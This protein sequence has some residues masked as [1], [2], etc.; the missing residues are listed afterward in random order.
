MWGQSWWR[1]NVWK[2]HWLNCWCLCQCVCLCS[3]YR[4]D[5]CLL[6]PPHLSCIKYSEERYGL[7]LSGQSIITDTD[8]YSPHFTLCLESD[9]ISYTLISDIWAECNKGFVFLIRGWPVLL[10]ALPVTMQ[11]FVLKCW[12]QTTWYGMQIYCI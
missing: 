7:K 4:G 12:I 1:E 10:I 9:T 2:H 8:L 6:R 11:G 5:I 3:G